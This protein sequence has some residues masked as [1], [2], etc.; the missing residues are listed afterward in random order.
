MKQS[1]KREQNTKGYLSSDC[2]LKLE[3][4]KLGSLGQG[5]VTFESDLIPLQPLGLL[6]HSRVDS[7]HGFWQESAAMNG[8]L[9]AGIQDCDRHLVATPHNVPLQRVFEQ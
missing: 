2:S 4:M 7:P 1:R 9:P 6:D 5:R 3:N 8:S